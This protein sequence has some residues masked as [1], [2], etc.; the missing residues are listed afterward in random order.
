MCAVCACAQRARSR[1]CSR[2]APPASPQPPR[3]FPA[4]LTDRLQLF[5]GGGWQ[6]R[7]GLGLEGFFFPSL[8]YVRG[9]RKSLLALSLPDTTGPACCRV[10]EEDQALPAAATAFASGGGAGKQAELEG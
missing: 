2:G 1:R 7:V 8:I 9:T 6:E 4:A 5:G 10:A 3:S